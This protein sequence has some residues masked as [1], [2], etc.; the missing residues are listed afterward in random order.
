MRLAVTTLFLVLVLVLPQHA[1]AHG[2]EKH[3]DS[4]PMEMGNHDMMDMSTMDH[5]GME[6][7]SNDSAAGEY[8]T[9]GDLDNGM[10]S[11][12]TEDDLLGLGTEPMP[13]E[14][15]TGMKKSMDHSGHA[16]AEKHIELATHEAV[17]S[18]SK[19]Y[20]LAVGVTVLSGLAFGF[21]MLVRPL[22]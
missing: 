17:S 22:E 13:M 19:G 7:G 16:M 3:E 21:L 6:M 8:G 18:S 11:L 14:S 2:G 5:G 9:E 4:A 12:G 1:L 10:P 20:G 15:S